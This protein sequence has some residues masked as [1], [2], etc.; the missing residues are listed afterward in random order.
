MSKEGDVFYVKK[1][2]TTKTVAFRKVRWETLQ[3]I[4]N[5]NADENVGITPP[6][7]DS[8]R[9][10]QPAKISSTVP[11]VFLGGFTPNC[12]VHIL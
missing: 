7:E 5:L 12:V 8:D 4:L 1:D 2:G 6:R 11:V 9:D 3:S 10:W